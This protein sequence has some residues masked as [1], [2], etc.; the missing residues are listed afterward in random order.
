MI[1]AP[2]TVIVTGAVGDAGEHGER[3]IRA[4]RIFINTGSLPVGIKYFSFKPF[5]EYPADLN[6]LVIDMPAVA[7]DPEN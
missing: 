3:A 6:W 7:D 5:I 1:F 2:N 4:E